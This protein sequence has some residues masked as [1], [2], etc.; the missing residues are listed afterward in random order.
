MKNQR[1]DTYKIYN[2]C[3]SFHYMLSFQFCY[4]KQNASPQNVDFQTT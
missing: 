3:V 1:P 2:G 4:M